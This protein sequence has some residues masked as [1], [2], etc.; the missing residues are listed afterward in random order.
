MALQ[1]HGLFFNIYGHLSNTLSRYTNSLIPQ[2][3]LSV[4][5]FNNYIAFAMPILYC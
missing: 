1:R 5:H 4:K 3:L 2:E